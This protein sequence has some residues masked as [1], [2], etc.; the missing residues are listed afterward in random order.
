MRVVDEEGGISVIDDDDIDI[1]EPVDYHLIGYNDIYSPIPFVVAILIEICKKSQN[2][3][4]EI[5]RKIHNEGKAI[6]W[7]GL[8]D[9]ALTKKYQIDFLSMK[10]KFPFKTEVLK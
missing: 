7:T 6:M 10:M 5:T 1:E 2:E 9:I 3:A 8:Y 4:E